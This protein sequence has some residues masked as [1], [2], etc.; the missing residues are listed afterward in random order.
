MFS[1]AVKKEIRVRILIKKR[2]IDKRAIKH[3]MKLVGI[4]DGLFPLLR[5]LYFIVVL[6]V[7]YLLRVWEMHFF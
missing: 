2:T 1:N 6:I 7:K 5:K 3:N 4:Y